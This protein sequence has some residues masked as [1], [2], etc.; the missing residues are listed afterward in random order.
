MPLT[1][2]QFTQQ[3][4]S[5]GLMTEDGLRGWLKSE[6]FEQW[7]SDG[8][9]LARE[10]VKHKKLT[11]FQASQIYAGKGASLVLGNYVI[12]DK[13]GQGGMGMVLKAE[14]K[15]MKRLVAVKVISAAAMKS[16][17]AVQ[18]FHREVEAAAKL[19]HPNIVN[20]NDADE[21][22]GTHFLVMEYIEGDDLSVLVKKGGP[23]SVNAAIDA[24][25][26]AARGLEYAHKRGVIHRDIKPANL[27]LDRE[28]TVKILDMG[29]ARIESNELGVQ[30]AELTNTGAI[31]GTID[32]MSPEQAED[33][34]HADAR[35]DI[36]SLGCSLYYLL[37]GHAVYTADTMMKKLLAHRTAPLPSLEDVSGTALAA[38]FSQGNTAPATP[39]AS[40]IP[41]TELDAVFHKMIAKKA[42]DRYQSM[43]EVVAALEQCRA[44]NSTTVA[45]STVGDGDS[46]NELQRFLRQMTDDDPDATIFEPAVAVATL[47]K[48]TRTTT[49]DPLAEE[50]MNSAGGEEQTASRLGLRPDPNRKVGTE[51]QPTRRTVTIVSIG[52]AS[53]V[54]MLAGVITYV[55]TN[56]GTLRIEIT[57]PLIEVAIQGT[58]IV[59]KDEGEE[60]VRLTPG[61]H[62]LHVKRGNLEF[63]T[64]AF[65]LKKGETVAV[66]VERIGRRVRAMSDKKLLGHRE[67]PKP[68]TTSTA[69]GWHGWPVDAPPPAIA[70]FNAEAAKQHQAAWA[71]F[72]KVPVEYTNSI[73]M[74]FILIPPGEFT[75]GS[76]PAEIEAA[77]KGVDPNDKQWQDGIK[78][79]APQHKVILTQPIYLGVH[80]VTQADY[81]KVMGNNP[82]H[83][84][85]MGPG[86]DHVVG[87]DT[88][89]HPVEKVSWNDAAEFCA[90]L[91]Q[92][93]KLKPFYFRAG[94]TITPVDGTGYRLPTEAEWEFACHAG[95]TTKYWIS[96]QDED[97]TRAG[98]FGTKS[99]GRTHAAGE[100]KANPFGLYDIHGNVWEW[101]QD[102]WEPTY[103]GEFQKKPALDPN[104]PSSAGSLRVI[105]GSSWYNYSASCRASGRHAHRPTNR[106]HGYGFRVSLLVDTAKAA[107]AE[108]TTKPGIATSGWHGWPA[109]APPPA[110][111][112]FNAEAAKQ[113]QA[114]WAKYLKL[115]VEYT[116]SLG[117][118][119]ILIPPGEFTMGSTS[120]EIEEVLKFSDPN[121]NDKHWQEIVKSEVPQHKVI[122]TQPIYL[123]VREVTQ[124]EYEKVMEKNPSHFAASGPG[125]DAVVGMDTTSHPVENVSWNDAA[126]F[127]AKLSQQE[128]LKSFYVR[129]AETVTPLNGTGYRL[130]TEAEWEFAC[131][132]GTTTKYWIGDKDDDLALAGWFGTNSG[133]RTHAAGELKANP[134]GLYDIHGNVLEWLQD[135]WEPTYYG[136]FQ[137]MPA[138]NPS[139]PTSAGSLRVWRGGNWLDTAHR[140]R[141]SHRYAHDPPHRMYYN[142]FRLALMVDAVRQALKESSALLPVEKVHDVISDT[143][144]PGQWYDVLKLVNVERHALDSK[145]NRTSD[146]I[147]R[148]FGRYAQMIVPV[149]VQGSY[150]LAFAFTR[151]SGDQDVVVHLPVGEDTSCTLLLSGGNGAGSGLTLVDNLDFNAQPNSPA[152]R[153][154][155]TL[156][157]FRKYQGRVQ[158]T[159]NGDE[160]QIEVELDGQPYLQWQGA[161]T[162][163]KTHFWTV[164]P[165]TDLLGFGSLA[166]VIFH[167]LRLKPLTTIERVWNSDRSDFAAVPEPKMKRTCVQWNGHWYGLSDTRMEFREAVALAQRHRAR[168]LQVSS[169]AEHDFIRA[170]W[171]K[172]GIWLGLWRNGNQVNPQ[173]SWLDQQLRPQPFFNWAPGEPNAGSGVISS[174][175]TADDGRWDDTQ[176]EN[177]Q[178]V[179]LEWGDDKI[180]KEASSARV[181]NVPTK[182]PANWP[183]TGRAVPPEK[184]KLQRDTW[185]DLLPLVD[186]DRHAIN[187]A[188]LRT[189]DG[190]HGLPCANSRVVVPLVVN[191]DYEL[192][193]SFTRY[194]GNEA[195]HLL[196]PVGPDAQTEL[197]LSGW[198]GQFSGLLNVGGAITPKQ[199]RSTAVRTPAPLENFRRYHATVRVTSKD[200][201]ASIEVRLNGEPYLA[202]T[203]PRR[204]LSTAPMEVSCD[205]PRR[206]LLAIGLYDV[207]MTYHE[208]RLRLLTGT[209]Q[210]WSVDMPSAA[211]QPPEAI[212]QQCVTCKETNKPYWIS[213]KPMNLTEALQLAHRHQARL[214]RVSSVAEREFLLKTWPD[215][216][217]WL[218]AWRN[219]Q[220]PDARIGWLDEKLRPLRY[221][222]P[223]RE[224]EPSNG[225]RD[226]S[227]VLWE[228]SHL[229]QDHDS[230]DKSHAVLE[231][232]EED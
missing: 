41:L 87:M 183:K 218:S 194:A 160:V 6:S 114:A 184:Q 161:R 2:E 143:L 54:L 173:L 190:L 30:Q 195:I 192:A 181:S 166:P 133:G 162:R 117:M 189:A 174:V 135:W 110:I 100:L 24:I 176:N 128:K 96:D 79:E 25:L 39:V 125:K 221:F 227:L 171:P 70:P 211:P 43:T 149:Q 198:G 65:T 20:A 48:R 127:S 59:V 44:G 101:V 16:K 69:S 40:A 167:E 102:W 60:D 97:L 199:P 179:C 187:G 36:Y 106:I 134:F 204:D 64:D 118:K 124:A 215:R 142:G 136:Q 108:G 95:T 13:L 137:G 17:D 159:L 186:V 220:E 157:N 119:F 42:S 225:G 10:L 107:I 62:T 153:R 152:I 175:I 202:W 90:K 94:E 37:A 155:G 93:E 169:R 113:H 129:A 231:W 34:K 177:A 46:G 207:P 145:W 164:L 32:Y 52:L 71:K 203:G 212:T 130:P 4:S 105:R 120:V 172:R 229:L 230:G 38:G 224:N 214:L 188:W 223:W 163:L 104:G 23:L 196:L 12:L 222:P 111:A 28:G 81:E 58:D 139:G 193:V 201:A 156:Q 89:S 51:S 56:R 141:V 92:Q 85:A 109:D 206:D 209:A 72:L 11:K 200:A 7:P 55:K 112:P 138:L 168:L 67:E 47:P 123:G 3:L 158:V 219:G 116:N 103:Y 50:T 14:H 115:P 191:G 185:Y 178:F 148:V 8:E 208:L 91:S 210:Q 88:T 144:P 68:K 122:L 86:K 84:A 73:G 78:S 74:K 18:R 22:K 147:A 80:E 9:E 83:F 228:T 53:V 21:A 226:F 132:A 140:S 197:S 216:R 146:G 182:L 154:P 33:T 213:P 63:D 49:T 232:G 19:T 170:Q 165:R 15:V 150:E 131:R 180:P 66:K 57:D 27:L 1:I 99:G 151:L 26:Q 217:I 82:S 77:L 76:T 205:P 29:L 121:A 98:W 5:S 75:M 61:E 31:M 126:E 45:R 35:A